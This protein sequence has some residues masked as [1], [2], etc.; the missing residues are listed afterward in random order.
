M[1]QA[2]KMEFWGIKLN[3]IKLTW[4]AVK[5]LIVITETIKPMIKDPVSPI[6]IFF[7][8]DR[9]NRKNAKSEPINEAQIK[10]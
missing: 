6:K 7:F 5:N 4:S 8:E 10:M 9:L 3:S 2:T 1:E